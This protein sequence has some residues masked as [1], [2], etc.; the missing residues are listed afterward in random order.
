MQKITKHRAKSALYNSYSAKSLK[1]KTVYLYKYAVA[2]ELIKTGRLEQIEQGE[3]FEPDEVLLITTEL[4]MISFGLPRVSR[5]KGV[6]APM[7]N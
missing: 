3:F 5:V 2:G 4:A 7:I 1:E 6:L